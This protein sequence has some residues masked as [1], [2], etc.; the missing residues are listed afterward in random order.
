MI[1]SFN[2]LI[3]D[4]IIFFKRKNFKVVREFDMCGKTIKEYV[5][6]LKRYWTDIW[7]P[8]RG[9]GPPI[10]KVTRDSDG[11]DVTKSVI[12]FSGPMKNYVNPLGLCTKKRKF[13]IRCKNLGLQISYENVW[14]P[15]KG[16]ITVTDTLDTIKKLNCV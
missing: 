9:T 15:Y 7:P 11:L 3:L 8:P 10:K 5:Y 4:F 13:V 1:D 2:M 12:K 14:E 16:S 6:N